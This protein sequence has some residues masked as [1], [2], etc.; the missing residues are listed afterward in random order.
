MS[1]SLNNLMCCKNQMQEGAEKHA[2]VSEGQSCGANAYPPAAED[3]YTLGDRDICPREEEG[4]EEK[5]RKRQDLSCCS[6]KSEASLIEWAETHLMQK[7]LTLPA[8]PPTSNF[9][10]RLSPLIE[11]ETE[12][13]S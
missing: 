2:E 4:Q 3:A 6:D 8:H 11:E 1:A 10:L 13:G 12:G 9:H 7:S 5:K